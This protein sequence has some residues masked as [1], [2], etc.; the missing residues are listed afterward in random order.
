MAKKKAPKK[1]SFLLNTIF[2]SD[3]IELNFP[4]RNALKKLVLITLNSDKHE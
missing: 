4:K 3:S 1:D 2:H